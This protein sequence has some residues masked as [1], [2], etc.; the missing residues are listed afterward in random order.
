[1]ACQDADEALD[2]LTR[3]SFDV[4]FLDM[5]MP[6]VGGLGLYEQIVERHSGQVRKFVFLS[7]AFSQADLAYL[8]ARHL[9]WVRK[10]VGAEELRDLVLELTQSS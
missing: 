10:P 4:G 3:G 6:G 9:P 7:G 8:E 1:V 2:A 5:H